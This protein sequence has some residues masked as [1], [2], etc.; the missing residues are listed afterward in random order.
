MVLCTQMYHPNDA[1]VWYK[2]LFE[3]YLHKG[4]EN[5]HHKSQGQIRELKFNCM[6]KSLFNLSMG[7]NSGSTCG[8][9]KIGYFFF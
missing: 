4:E 6:S 9:F 2:L 1:K 7:Y 8:Y 5:K 3:R